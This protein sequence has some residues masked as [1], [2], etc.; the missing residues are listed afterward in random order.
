M[1]SVKSEGKE[2]RTMEVG[3]LVISSGFSGEARL[4]TFPQDEFKGTTCHSSKHKG[5]R[6]WEGKKAVVVG[7]CNSGYVLM[8]FRSRKLDSN[9]TE[10]D[11]TLLPTSMRTV[12]M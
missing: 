5:A 6:G 12:S 2:T 7:C 4:P 3:H 1:Y 9:V 8:R 11:T 10:I